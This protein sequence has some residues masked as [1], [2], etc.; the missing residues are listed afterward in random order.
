ML[1]NDDQYLDM[2]LDLANESIKNGNHPFGSIIVLDGKVISKGLNEVITKNDITLHA[3]MRAIQKAQQEVTLEALAKSTLYTS[4]EPCAMC[5]GAIYW[6][7][8]RNIVFG[9][10]NKQLSSIAG[11]TLEISSKEI[12]K[13]DE[14]GIQIKDCSHHKKFEQIHRNFW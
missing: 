10:S 3:E 11:K 8:I 1:L 5:C 13:R 7:G 12:L 6:A 4:T 2:C 9:A 14:N